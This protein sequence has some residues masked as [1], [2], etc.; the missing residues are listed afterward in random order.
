[1]SG[2]QKH[3]PYSFDFCPL[4][5]PAEDL[6]V[7]KM[8][9]SASHEDEV[10]AQILPLDPQQEYAAL[11]WCWGSREVPKRTMRITHRDQPYDFE[12]SASLDSALKKLRKHKVEYLWIDQ[13]C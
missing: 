12:I 13:I 4:L 10:E 2:L 11:S 8:T 1:M 6:R 9:L 7:L 3:P 5:N